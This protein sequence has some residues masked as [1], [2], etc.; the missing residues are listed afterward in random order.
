MGV[1][2]DICFHALRCSLREH[3]VKPSDLNGR[4]AI[5][6]YKVSPANY[7]PA[8]ALPAIVRERLVGLGHA[9]SIFALADRGAAI[10][11]GLHQF[12]CKTMRHGF[13]AAGGGRLDHPSHRQSLATIGTH[14]DRHLVGGPADATGFD[15]DYG[16][17]I[18]QRLLQH[19]NCFA[20]G[21]AAFVA[22]AIDGAID[23]LF[24]GGLLAALHHHVD[25]FG[26]HVVTELG[27]RKNGAMRGCCSAGHGKPLFL[28]AFGAVL[29]SALPTV[30]DTGAIE[31]TADSVISD[32]GQILDAAAADQYH[33]VV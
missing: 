33:R 25:E 7:Q 29:G 32:P 3:K 2:R 15:F 17:D 19:S 28:G 10:L 4:P 23:D 9:V 30:A 14:F 5:S 16:F 27:V 31:R 20:A 6:L 22:D 11:G 13:L 24:G 1:V 12:G 8:R 18:I 26:Q 21:W